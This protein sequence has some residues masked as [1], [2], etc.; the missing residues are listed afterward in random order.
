[1]TTA[2]P[3]ITRQSLPVGSG[4][5]FDKFQQT[6]DEHT[7]IIEWYIATDKIL[8]F[9]IKPHGQ[10]LTLWQS[11]PED[12]VALLNWTIE[13]LSDYYNPTDTYKDQWQNQLEE[14]L[15]KLAKI[16][17][18]EEILNLA[19]IPKDYKLILIPHRF[20]HL[21]PLHALPVGESYLLD[22]FPNGVSY[23]PSCQ[24]LQQVQLRQ[25]P[26]F[27]SLFAIQ[28]PTEDLN[29]AD[30][31]VESLLPLFSSHQVLPNSQ[32]TKA[33]LSA[34]T[35]QLK[36]VN[37][38]HFS[39]HGFFNPNSPLDSC[40]VLAN[41]YISS[42]EK[43]LDLNKCLTLGNLFERDFELNQCRLVVLSACET[44]LIDFNNSSDEYIGL[45]SGFLYA[46]S[47]DVV[48][49]LWTVN[50]LSTS[51]LIIKFLQNFQTALTA[52]QDI[53]VASA[54]KEA[55]LWL[56]NATKE[57]LQEWADTLQLDSTWNRL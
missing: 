43:A 33:A 45:P 24:I 53:S 50:D 22:L 14:R 55:Q 9:V 17:H 48:N 46:G 15:Q 11:Q 8:A 6:L 7:A 34:A 3:R 56:R 57:K 52:S 47:V 10:E 19:Q 13:Y 27:K 26:D 18:F 35:P 5:K 21:F 23:A 54:L 4:F 16:L 42:N 36:E 41:P 51:F 30:L 38:L 29:Y 25:R 37:S 28:N 31:E 44:G 40:L 49:S 20:L 2:A 39:C 1:M 32:A 12:L